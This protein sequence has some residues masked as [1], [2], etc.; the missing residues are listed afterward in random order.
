VEFRHERPPT[1]AY[2]LSRVAATSP[3]ANFSWPSVDFIWLDRG[4]AMKP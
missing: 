1:R 4:Q 2:E 3:S